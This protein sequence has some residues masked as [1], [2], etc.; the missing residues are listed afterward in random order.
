MSRYTARTSA[1]TFVTW[2]GQT[3]GAAQRSPAPR[4]AWPTTPAV[5]ARL[6]A[7]GLEPLWLAG[8]GRAASA[9][10]KSTAPCTYEELGYAMLPDP[11]ATLDP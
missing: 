10:T 7:D 1:V 6:Y 11:G 5:M 4:T 3:N 9:G 8:G 2:N